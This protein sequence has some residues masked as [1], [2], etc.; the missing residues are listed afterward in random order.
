MSHSHSNNLMSTPSTAS[1][2]EEIAPR[3]PLNLQAGSEPIFP[4]SCSPGTRP[5]DVHRRSWVRDELKK[6]IVAAGEPEPEIVPAKLY[7]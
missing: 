6:L 4:A 5:A 2:T 1:K 3:Q 7:T